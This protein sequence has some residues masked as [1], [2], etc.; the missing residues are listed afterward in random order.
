LQ[1]PFTDPDDFLTGILTKEGNR[2][3][4]LLD[5]PDMTALV[6]KQQIELD[7]NKRLQLVF[8]VQRAHADKMYYPP[9][10]YTKAYSFQQPWVQNHFV[11]DDYDFGTEEY[12]YMSVNNK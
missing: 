6:K 7:E 10:I 9:I 2:N 4:D 3:E 1:T 8:D 12:A 5:D 11:A